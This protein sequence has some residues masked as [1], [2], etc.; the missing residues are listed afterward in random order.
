MNIKH[1]PA[2]SVQLD[3]RP[4]APGKPWPAIR[5]G[6]GGRWGIK[7]WV[8]VPRLW[9]VALATKK[10]EVFVCVSVRVW[11]STLGVD[12][13]EFWLSKQPGAVF[14]SPPEVIRGLLPVGLLQITPKIT[15][16]Y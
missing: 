4:P 11:D 15:P 3:K 8:R 10:I 7:T 5:R 12:L 9:T 6:A 14:Y 1:K 2:H 16:K 13:L